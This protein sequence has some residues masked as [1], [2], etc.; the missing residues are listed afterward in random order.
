MVACDC[1]QVRVVS[2]RWKDRAGGNGRGRL[3]AGNKRGEVFVGGSLWKGEP[4]G[5]NW[6]ETNTLQARL[7]ENILN[8]AGAA[9]L[10]GWNVV[11]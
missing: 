7:D 9:A 1:N 3:V 4:V 11:G 6:A 2:H 10:I 8:A 5:S